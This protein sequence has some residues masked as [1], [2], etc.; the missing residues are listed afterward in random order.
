MKRIMIICS[1]ALLALLVSTNVNAAAPAKKHLGIATYSVKGLESNI[2]GAFKSLQEAG[3]V[4][5]EISN[6]N[7]GTGMVA[8]YKP[9]DY[10]AL[11]EKYGM[12]II[13]SHARAAFNV[14]DVPGTVAA[15]AKLFDDHK[16]MGCKYVVFPMNTSWSSKVEGLKAECDLMNKIG[17]EANKRG[18]KFGYHNHNMEFAT[19]PGTSQMYEDFLIANTDPSKVFFQLDVYWA[20]V[21][22]VNPAEYIK[23]H[24]DRIKVLH[25]KD[26]YVIGESGTI[27]YKAIFEQ[28]YKNGYEDWFVEMEAK[29]TPEQKAQSLDRMKAMQKAMSEGTS[30][31]P[32]GAPQ[33]G[34]QG[35]RPQGQGQPGQAQAQGQPQQG[36]QGAQRPQGQGQ[37]Q[38]APMGPRQQDPA[39]VAEQLKTSLE[40]IKAS[41]DYLLKAEFVK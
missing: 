32:F 14:N 39:V 22:G 33:G 6:Y 3:Y 36:Q 5:M 24:A 28:F 8:G 35:A 15:W 23:K 27:D 37:Q 16:A 21:G 38:G 18:I 26:D 34:Q 10:A 12:D 40:G 30:S 9:A 2:E 31:N 29:M 11:A 1:V 13:S 7:A 25:I 4:T 19:I 17:E 20:S 41:A